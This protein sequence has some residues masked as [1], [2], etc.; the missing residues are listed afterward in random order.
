MN[1]EIR[2]IK[3][4]EYTLKSGWLDVGHGHRVWYEQWGNPKA[5]TPILIFHGGPG[6]E[7]KP[8]H[9]YNFD[10]KVHHVIGFDQRGCGNSLP[11]GKTQ[12]NRTDDLIE[13]ASAILDKLRI[14]NV[15]VNGGS[16]GSTLALLFALKYPRRVTSLTLRGTFTGSKDEIS[17]IDQG[18]Y[19]NYYP[20]VWQRF[21][22]S[23]PKKYAD[24]PA[25]FHYD[26]L[27][28]NDKDKWVDSAKALEDLE[29]PVMLT[30]W[31][32]YSD[33]KSD[34]TEEYD[35]VPYKIYAWYLSHGSFLPDNYILNNAH[36]IKVPTYIINGRYD[37]VCPPKT[38]YELHDSIKNS[39]LFI[40]YDNHSGG[41]Q[42]QLVTKT[43][44]EMIY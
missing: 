2:S 39:K 37:M 38:A 20:E 21:I 18:L 44:I 33:I 3:T 42:T 35:F 19:R 12:H 16:W 25:K 13:D 17:W 31:P 7:F 43:L 28:G 11:Y 9:K 34:K 6:G 4:D 10:P 15:H 22:T 32:G 24:N 1:L 14:K 5:K 41:P 30:E 40:T 26:I 36:K 8:K 29:V 23:V 27:N